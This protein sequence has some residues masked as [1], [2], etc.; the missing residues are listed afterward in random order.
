M[1]QGYFDQC[2]DIISELEET[3]SA[4][5]LTVSDLHAWAFGGCKAEIPEDGLSKGAIPSRVMQNRLIDAL[6][7]A[8]AILSDANEVQI[9]MIGGEYEGA[10]DDWVDDL[11]QSAQDNARQDDK[12]EIPKAVM[13]AAIFQEW[14]N[15]LNEL[16]GEDKRFFLKRGTKKPE[17]LNDNLAFTDGAEAQASPVKQAKPETLDAVEVARKI[18]DESNSIV[19]GDHV[20]PAP[21][22]E[23]PKSGSEV[24]VVAISSLKGGK[25]ENNL[26]DAQFWCGSLNQKFYLDSRVMHSSKEA[27]I[28]HAKALIAVSKGE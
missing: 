2:N 15:T 24:F 6:E 8:T 17:C 14:K 7:H 9:F 16:S 20:V 22:S 4:L 11:Q 18:V 1:Q 25:A 12:L 19:I 28:A 27:A 23:E 3:L 5:Q 10:P 13:H 21:M 26:Y